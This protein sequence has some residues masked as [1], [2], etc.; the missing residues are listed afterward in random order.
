M[1]DING[2][3]VKSLKVDSLTN[4]QV[5]ISDLAQGIYTVKISSENGSA[6]KKIVKE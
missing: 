3:T 1:F 4:A 5:N 2:R 6:T